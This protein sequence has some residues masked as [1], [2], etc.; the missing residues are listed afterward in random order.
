MQ[1]GPHLAQLPHSVEIQTESRQK[2]AQMKKMLSIRVWL[3]WGATSWS[4]SFRGGNRK[5]DPVTT[6]HIT[7]RTWR[8]ALKPLQDFQSYA[9][10]WSSRLGVPS[11][12]SMLPVSRHS[13]FYMIA[14]NFIPVSRPREISPGSH[15]HRSPCTVTSKKARRSSTGS[16]M[17]PWPT[18]STSQH[19]TAG[20][21]A[22]VFFLRESR[23]MDAR[24][25]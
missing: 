23:I 10:E 21:S 20:A 24:F 7:A 15:G 4:A 9:A 17:A 5:M 11:R 18:L 14:A 6:S 13:P 22:W 19:S 12:I 3:L 25:P 2:V 1:K 8:P 16:R